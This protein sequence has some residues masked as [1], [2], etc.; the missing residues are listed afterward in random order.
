MVSVPP[1]TRTFGCMGVIIPVDAK[2]CKVTP[3][4][5]SFE[6]FEL[7]GGDDAVLLLHGFS[8]STDEMRELGARLHARGY[9]ISAPAL[10][11]HRGDVRELEHVTD[12]DYFAMALAQFDRLARARKRV[13]VAGLS[14]GGAL[15]LYIAQH[16]T[17]AA[18]ITISTPVR[19]PSHIYGGVHLVARHRASV[20]LPVNLNAY[21]GGIGYPTVPASAVR[22]FLSVVTQ[23]R[24]RLPDVHCPLLVLHSARDLTVPF[25]NAALIDASVGSVD[26]D[27]VVFDEGQHLMTVG[28]G[29][30]VIEPYVSEFLIR[31]D[32]EHARDGRTPAKPS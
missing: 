26:R 24:A 18:V 8:G 14:M 30:D 11:G 21:F 12:E 6:P 16:R 19:M 29:L 10:P 13:Y 3:R 22:T 23:V 2:R 27:V 20:H 4:K 9:D 17:P 7:P 32:R 1:A 31:V 25:A 15:G 28:R 5:R